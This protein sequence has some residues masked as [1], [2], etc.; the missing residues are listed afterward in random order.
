MR[1]GDSLGGVALSGPDRSISG[2]AQVVTV[3]GGEKALYAGRRNAGRQENVLNDANARLIRLL[4]A[5]HESASSFAIVAS[6]LSP[7]FSSTD[8]CSGV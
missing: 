2:R 6:K 3:T 7:M 8:G 5:L 4:D 1:F